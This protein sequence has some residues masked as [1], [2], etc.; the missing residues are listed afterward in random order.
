ME[1]GL[2]GQ[3]KESEERGRWRVVGEEMKRVS[4]IAGPMAGVVMLQYML[5]VVSQMMAG[6]L[7]PLYLSSTAIAISISTVTGFS[8]LFGM[9]SALE[10]L[11]GQAYGAQQ[12]RK[13]GTQTYTAVVSLTLVCIPISI[14]WI[15]M[16]RVLTFLGQ[17]P[18][19]SYEAGKFS[20]C[21]VPA[22]FA[23]AILQPLVRYFQ[24]QS[25]VLPMLVIS[26]VTLCIHIP[27]CWVLVFNS[28]LHNLGAAVAMSI[29]FWVNLVFLV[30]YMR[31]SPKC[32][33]TRSSLSMEIF[34]GMG[35][36]FS[37][38]IPSATMTCL[39]WWSFELLILLSGLM[40]RP[41]LETSVLSICLTTIATLYAIPYGLSAAASTR[42][43]NE[44]GAGNPQEARTAA[45]A[46]M[47]MEVGCALTLCSILFTTRNV[48]GYTFSNEDEVVA[49]V[50]AMA[51]LICLNVIIDGLQCIL[52]G[53]ARGC[54]WQDIGA[55]VN[56]GAYYLF[57]IPIAATLG[58]WLQLRGK[59]LWIGVLCGSTLQLVLLSIITFFTNWE[60][61]VSKA[62]ERL[63]E[64]NSKIANGATIN[65]QRLLS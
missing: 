2:L 41:E 42:I 35:E 31:F 52:S 10:T 37:Y 53:V 26:F 60:K 63:L 24:V 47:M 15:N 44:L 13:L 19:I 49:Y 1:E 27:L 36:F 12:Y 14:L 65:D 54:G 43:S 16:G 7:G 11:S 30:L 59:G 33:A 38:A 51:P 25:L 39:E 57:G 34:H 62:R 48:F 8:F 22:L 46:A 17:D 32:V 3:R 18:T 56:L 5:Q 6:H 20:T 29:S 50:T 23:V 21:L 28:G 58:F 45:C 61:Q 55:Y 40:P 4:S 64:S 9:A